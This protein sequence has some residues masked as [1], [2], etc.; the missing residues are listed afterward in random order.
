MLTNCLWRAAALLGV[1]VGIL[2]AAIL[3]PTLN[4]VRTLDGH[5]GIVFAVSWASDGQRIATGAQDGKVRVWDQV[6]TKPTR[7]DPPFNDYKGNTLFAVKFSP[8]SGAILAAGDSSGG[9]PTAIVRQVG[10]PLKGWDQNSAAVG[11]AVETTAIP[12]VAVAEDKRVSVRDFTKQTTR[13]F[14]DVSG[15]LKAIAWRDDKVASGDDQQIVAV[16]DPAN[17]GADPVVKIET[18][19]VVRSVGLSSGGTDSALRGRRRRRGANPLHSRGT[20]QQASHRRGHCRRGRVSQ[21]LDDR[22]GRPGD[23]RDG[24]PATGPSILGRRD[25][26][27]TQALRTAGLVLRARVVGRRHL[28][29]LGCRW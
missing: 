26:H 15:N 29:C 24:Y 19:S 23:P 11:L 27:T 10:A 1:S 14:A 2:G 9:P 17:A 28:R 3:A 4:E 16:W 6:A 25:R 5:Q 8:D 18:P 12:R 21:W 22:R 13:T 20:G 7:L